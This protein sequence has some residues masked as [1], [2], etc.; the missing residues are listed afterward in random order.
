[1]AASGRG[2]EEG[3]RTGASAAEQAAH[4]RRQRPT[5]GEGSDRA[6][7]F[8]TRKEIAMGLE[9]FGHGVA[10]T[11]LVE[12]QRP[13]GSV[14]LLQ[15]APYGGATTPPASAGMTVASSPSG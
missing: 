7:Q 9:I 5:V 1:M 13:D 12:D 3:A 6:K 14:I 11:I 15:C 4:T 10:G 2:T 8:V